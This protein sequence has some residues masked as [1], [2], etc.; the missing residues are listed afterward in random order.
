MSTKKDRVGE[1]NQMQD[2]RLAEIIKYDDC[3]H[4]TLSF[5]DG[6]IVPRRTKR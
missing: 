4:I 2:G 5:E 3:S 6:E 1:K